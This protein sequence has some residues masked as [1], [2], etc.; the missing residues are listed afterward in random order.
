MSAWY[1]EIDPFAAQWLRELIKAGL[2]A[3]GEVDERDIRDVQADDVRGFTQCHFFAGIGGWSLALRLAGWDDGRHVWTFSCPC[4][5]FSSATRGRA[6]ADDLWPEQRRL[7]DTS[8]PRVFFG[9]QVPAREW[10]DGL[11][12]DVDA[13][14]Y[15]VGAAVLPAVV[16]GADHA[17]PRLY[18]VGYSNRNSQPVVSVDAEVD[19]LLR[20]RSI[21]RSMEPTYGV[22]RDVVALSGFGN[23]IV[24]QVAQAF[25]ESYLDCERG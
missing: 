11:C 8:R 1:N 13:L 23:A 25:I 10:C 17:R 2:I 5:R 7:I 24:P 22:S 9:E 19:R 4:Q 18:F 6:V 3:D 14:G 12:S 20:H 16:V 15:E 21:T